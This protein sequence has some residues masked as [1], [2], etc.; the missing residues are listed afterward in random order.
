MRQVTPSAEQNLFLPISP[1]K[2]TSC[3]PKGG[4]GGTTSKSPFL[5]SFYVLAI[6]FMEIPY[7]ETAVER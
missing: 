1:L 4:G 3:P 7:V 2:M 6:S 5:R